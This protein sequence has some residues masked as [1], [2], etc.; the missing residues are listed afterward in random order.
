MPPAREGE[1]LFIHN[2]AHDQLPDEAAKEHNQQYPHQAAQHGAGLCEHGQAGRFFLA[3]TGRGGVLAGENTSGGEIDGKIIFPDL[4]LYGG[5][6]QGQY[7][8][9]QIL[10]W[11]WRAG[12]QSVCS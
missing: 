12:L 7:A 3:G 2:P 6:P 9:Q 11:A 10:P 5:I 8:S 4:R 1:R